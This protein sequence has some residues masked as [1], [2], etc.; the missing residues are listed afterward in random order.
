M[1]GA[2]FVRPGIE[3]IF[4]CMAWVKRGGGS[5]A[6]E[7]GRGLDALVGREKPR[8]E[9]SSPNP[10]PPAPK[11]T[12]DVPEVPLAYRTTDWPEVRS[13]RISLEVIASWVRDGNEGCTSLYFDGAQVALGPDSHHLAAACRGDA[14]AG[15]NYQHVA[16]GGR[17]RTRNGGYWQG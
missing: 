17:Y 4:E 12:P 8:D 5:G 3:G 9:P 1:V 15:S 13:V 10:E 2:V 14:G 6:G 11:T 16:A 7:Y